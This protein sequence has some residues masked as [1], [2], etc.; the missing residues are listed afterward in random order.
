M[1]IQLLVV[2]T[3]SLD[4]LA[5]HTY[6]LVRIISKLEGGGG[7]VLA[8]LV[9]LVALAALAVSTA[10]AALVAMDVTDVLAVLA[11]FLVMVALKI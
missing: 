2:K 10:L 8:V 9:V 3:I 11:V 6:I 4:T 5:A 7:S 1:E